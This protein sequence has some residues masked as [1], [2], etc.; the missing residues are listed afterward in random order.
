MSDMYPDV[1]HFHPVID[2]NLAK[3]YPFLISKATEGTS[4]IDPTLKSF[5]TGCENNGIPY[6]LYVFLDP[7]AEL[8]QVKYLVDT[9][10]VIIG[11]HFVGYCIDSEHGSTA[12]SLQE[13]LNWLKTQSPKTMLYTGYKDYD[14]YKSV[15]NSRGNECAWW[16]SRYGRNTDIYNPAYPPHDGADLHQFTSNIVLP[17]IKPGSSGS[18]SSRLTGAIPE[19]WFTDP[20]CSGVNP[21]PKPSRLFKRGDKGQEVRWI[22]YELNRTGAGLDVDGNFGPLTQQAIIEYMN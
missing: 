17:G 13:A 14:L 10:G 18:D 21:W 20:S 5:I 8:A 7:G 11:R 3:R 6:W 16:E 4:F 2:W 12:N 15:I 19:S 22:Q 1:N 9:C